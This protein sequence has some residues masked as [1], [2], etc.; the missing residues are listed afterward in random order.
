M[1]DNFKNICGIYKINFP[2]GKSYIGLSHNI[3]QRLR[4]HYYSHDNLPVHKAIQKYGLKEENIEILESFE[5]VDREKL[6]EREKYW[7][8]YYQT[9]IFGY[10]LTT[11]G[12]GASTGI[13]NISAKL[14]ETTLN[15][16]VNE[17]IENKI[18]IKD[19]AKKYNLTPESISDINQGKRYFN[20]NLKYPL[21]P[22]TKF[23]S[24]QLKQIR[25]CDNPNSIFTPEQLEEILYELEFGDLSQKEISIKF[26]C[27]EGTIQKIN[28]GKRYFNSEL[29]YPIRKQK[30]SKTKVSKEML[31]E[32]IN[33]LQNTTIPIKEIAERFKLNKATVYK[34]N[35]GQ[36]HFQENFSYPIRK[37]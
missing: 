6:Q 22:S 24:E 5:E 25:G 4:T 8:A 3:Q 13:N 19:L 9:Y 26:H 28:V 36:T 31:E 21:R 37:N 23:T 10:N 33:L 2:S 29:S 12:D 32:I 16:L 7:I 15:E 18:Y 35:R 14:T 1:F 34:I 11:G 20:K 17:L 27:S 30:V